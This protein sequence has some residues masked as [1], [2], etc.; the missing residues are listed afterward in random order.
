[1]VGAAG[2]E[3]VGLVAVARRTAAGAGVVRGGGVVDTGSTLGSDFGVDVIGLVEV[4][5][6]C[7]GTLTVR[8]A[9]HALPSVEHRVARPVTA[10]TATMMGTD[11]PRAARY[12]GVRC[13]RG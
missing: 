9:C 3:V 4:A 10:S 2:I 7:P 6:L 11:T 13:L 8:G 1:M 12:V 5:I